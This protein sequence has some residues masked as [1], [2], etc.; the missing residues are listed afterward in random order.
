[1]SQG[2][3]T[4]VNR[5]TVVV[6]ILSCAV[7][8]SACGGPEPEESARTSSSAEPSPVS[9]PSPTPSVTSPDLKPAIVISPVQSVELSQYSEFTHQEASPVGLPPAAMAT[10]QDVLSAMTVPWVEEARAANDTQECLEGEQKCGFFSLTLE[11]LPCEYGLLCVKQT[12]GKAGIGMATGE[13]GVSVVRIDPQT[14]EDTSLIDVLGAARTADFLAALNEAATL[15]QKSND[16]YFEESPPTY[17]VS[18]VPAW[19]PTPD[20]VRV[21]FPRYALGPG[22]LG[23]VEI[24][25]RETSEG[26]RGEPLPP[27]GE[28]L[29]SSFDG[30]YGFICESD[31]DYLPR[32]MNRFADP[33]AVSVLQRLLAD[34]TESGDS[35]IYAGEVSGQ[36]DA[37]TRQAVKRWQSLMA[38]EV[39]GLV[40][41]RTW[42][43]LQYQTCWHEE[44]PETSQQPEGGSGIGD[45]G[46]DVVQ[47]PLLV[48]LLNK[49]AQRTAGL[50]GLGFTARALGGDP[51]VAA[52]ATN[53]CVIVA[54]DP[55]PGAV[56]SRGALV[57]AEMLCPNTG[58]AA[59]GAPQPWTGSGV[60]GYT[61][62]P[63][64]PAWTGR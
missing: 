46:T 33:Y 42:G 15:I 12:V 2:A 53:G 40:G 51:S 17:D 18:S 5:Q 37:E 57:Q 62:P 34:F 14:G 20:G 38:I 30:A 55:L 9:E 41:P 21:W 31:T 35:P 36:Y 8:L 29:V 56:V 1:M 32:L 63:P 13:G 54:Q 47:V 26:Y 10:A 11:W 22:S 49:D 61:G 52:Q 6:A 59:P 19:L 58:Y 64:P 27:S 48:G 4:M 43:T 7:L 60:G 24:L 50:A 23:I 28:D 3:F 25:M 44:I 16:A 45:A 39:D